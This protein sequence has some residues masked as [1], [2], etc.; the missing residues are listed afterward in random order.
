MAVTFDGFLYPTNLINGFRA[1]DNWVHLSGE[2]FPVTAAFRANA[3]EVVSYVE[4]T[5]KVKVSSGAFVE[6]GK[7][8]VTP[9][10]VDEYPLDN[11]RVYRAKF[12]DVTLIDSYTP[13]TMEVEF[14]N[15]NWLYGVHYIPLNDYVLTYKY[16]VKAYL[17]D[18]TSI[19]G[20]E[21][22]EIKCLKGARTRNNNEW[23]R[24]LYNDAYA[25]R[26]NAEYMMGFLVVGNGNLVKWIDNES[27]TNSISVSGIVYI[28]AMPEQGKS[29][30]IEI[31]GIPRYHVVNPSRCITESLFLVRFRTTYGYIDALVFDGRTS[32]KRSTTRETFV[33]RHGAWMRYTLDSTEITLYEATAR[34]GV[35]V[36]KQ[37]VEETIV[38][39]SQSLATSDVLA[40]LSMAKA[41]FVSDYTLPIHA[42]RYAIATTS[43]D[44]VSPTDVTN[45]TI[46]LVGEQSVAAL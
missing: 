43:F 6:I 2:P 38:L 14:A 16:S 40:E 46:E 23:G 28:R 22:M 26:K 41:I 21:T 25:Y 18:N 27:N 4:F 1:T 20:G 37:Y 39:N 42:R 7:F 9:E 3:N 45:L 35:R 15:P 10:V 44:D 11:E 30:T 8:S 19:D 33:R 34:N 13:E 29:Y 32:R 24:I 12:Y 5:F 17:S 36:T 31:D